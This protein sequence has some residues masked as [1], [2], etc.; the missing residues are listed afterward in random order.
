MG[1]L[2]ERAPAGGGAG[3]RLDNRPLQFN[4][5]TWAMGH[6]I[7]GFSDSPEDAFTTNAR[8]RIFSACRLRGAKAH[9]PRARGGAG[10]GQHKMQRAHNRSEQAPS[11]GVRIVCMLQT[12]V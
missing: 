6:G 7:L 1:V 12:Q 5:A 10:A 3:T 2:G 11:H 4:D 9:G 8:G